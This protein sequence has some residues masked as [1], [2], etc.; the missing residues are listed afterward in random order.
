MYTHN[1][2]IRPSIDPQSS[3]CYC[4]I[5]LYVLSIHQ[6]LI[7]L[8]LCGPTPILMLMSHRYT[9]QQLWHMGILNLRWWL[10]IAPHC[11]P[12][13]TVISMIIRIIAE[14]LC[15]STACT[16]LSDWTRNGGWPWFPHGST[17]PLHWE[18]T[19]LQQTSPAL[20]TITAVQGEQ[21]QSRAC[22]HSNKHLLIISW[23]IQGYM[24]L[25]AVVQ[26]PA[27]R[28][29][30]ARTSEGR[31][32]ESLSLPQTNIS[33]FFLPQSAADEL[34]KRRGAKI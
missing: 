31:F 14:F 24:G 2:S 32:T 10:A 17:P 18:L 23:L 12:P 13:L 20:L 30:A 19:R 21:K 22:S 1:L 3:F 7:S 28:F 33:D 4:I 11:S 15:P 26:L 29:L 25:L 27:L 8:S 5:K 34:T 6:N 16:V 9:V